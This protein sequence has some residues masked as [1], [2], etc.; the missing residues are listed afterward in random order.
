V[1]GRGTKPS[2]FFAPWTSGSEKLLPQRFRNLLPLLIALKKDAAFASSQAK[3]RLVSAFW[4]ARQASDW[5]M[6]CAERLRRLRK[7]YQ[8]EA[9][10]GSW[11]GIPHAITEITP[12]LVA[13]PLSENAVKLLMRFQ[14]VRLETFGSDQWRRPAPGCISIQLFPDGFTVKQVLYGVANWWERDASTVIHGLL[15][16]HFETG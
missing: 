4:A 8:I 5:G 10:D 7:L 3:D 14:P 2:A 1:T 16:G 9:F 15:E 6:D 12:E 13:A 11:E